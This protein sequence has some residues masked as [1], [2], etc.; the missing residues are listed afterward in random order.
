M[1]FF[2]S[3]VLVGCKQL[4]QPSMPSITWSDQDEPP[5]YP[6]CEKK[7]DIWNCFETNIL[8]FF[9]LKI[10][11]NPIDKLSPYPDT[12]Y[13]K[14][15]VNNKGRINL[16][17]IETVPDRSTEDLQHYFQSLVDQLPSVG[18]ATKTNLGVSTQTSFTL[19]IR[20]HLQKH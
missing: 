16:Q 20:I 5:I 6:G 11:S 13:L 14:L 4:P 15:L 7:I 17:A 18:P 12:V 10:Q 19:P 9:H 1:C 3:L 2:L 8:L